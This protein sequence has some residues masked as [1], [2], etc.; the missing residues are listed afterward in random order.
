MQT[1][2]N[3]PIGCGCSLDHKCSFLQFFLSTCCLPRRMLICH[4]KLFNF[5]QAF[6]TDCSAHFFCACLHQNTVAAA[7][8]DCCVFTAAVLKTSDRVLCL[9]CV[10]VGFTQLRWFQ[11]EEG[12]DLRVSCQLLPQP[13]L[14]KLFLV[15]NLHIPLFK[16]ICQNKPR[17]SVPSAH[18]SS[19]P[20]R[21]TPF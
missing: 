14:F 10:S 8:A 16:K 17:L 2:G 3:D 20:S 12:T 4:A 11:S 18:T 5:L 21:D 9:L 19:L 1:K 7:A 15:A 6:G 13:H